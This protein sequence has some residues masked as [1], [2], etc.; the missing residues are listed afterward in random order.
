MQTIIIYELRN[1]PVSRIWNGVQCVIASQRT[2]NWY[3]NNHMVAQYK[4]DGQG[5][6]SKT[7][8]ER[9][10]IIEFKLYSIKLLQ[11]STRAVILSMEFRIVWNTDKRK[12][13]NYETEITNAVTFKLQVNVCNTDCALKKAASICSSYNKASILPRNCN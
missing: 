1:S 6:I 4:Y 3:N 9:M 12:K 13:N 2:T 7:L 8:V 10:L 5:F 11:P